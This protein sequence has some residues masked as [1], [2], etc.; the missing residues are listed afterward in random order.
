MV[1]KELE[2]VA[3]ELF[4]NKYNIKGYSDPIWKQI[5]NSL[6]GKLS[7]NSLYINVYQDCHSCQTILLKMFISPCYSA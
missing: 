5:S 7:A 3:S 2:S 6:D 4:D 1:L